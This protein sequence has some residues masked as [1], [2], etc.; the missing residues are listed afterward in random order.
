MGI[1]LVVLLLIIVCWPWISRW[2]R[3]FM[4]RRAEDA[5]RRMMGMPTRG[6]ERKARRKAE[7]A[8]GAERR[9]E[10]KRR[11]HRPAREDAAVIMKSVAED[12]EF[13]EIREFEQHSSLDAEDN[14]KTRRIYREEQVSDA[15]YTVI[16]NGKE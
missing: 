10:N 11:H 16:S 15:E 13:V 2:L 4:Q 3:G 7:R 1:F 12:A 5:F 8:A 6:E 9:S 14:G